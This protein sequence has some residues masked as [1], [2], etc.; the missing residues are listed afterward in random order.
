MTWSLKDRLPD[1]PSPLRLDE[2]KLFNQ[3]CCTKSTFFRDL[4]LTSCLVFSVPQIV[5]SSTS[6]SHNTV[7]P[8]QTEHCL[9]LGNLLTTNYWPFEL[10]APSPP[11]VSRSEWQFLSRL[12]QLSPRCRSKLCTTSVTDTRSSVDKDACSCQNTHFCLTSCL[13]T[14]SKV[15]GQRVNLILCSA[16]AL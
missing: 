14:Y 7:Q 6:N 11:L 5:N 8:S 16:F 2:R 4:Q 15:R 12:I 9:L 3:H 13:H 10:S 1:W